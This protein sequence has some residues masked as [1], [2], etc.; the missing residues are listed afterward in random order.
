VDGLVSRYNVP[1]SVDNEFSA[2]DD[3]APLSPEWRREIER[4]KAACERGDLETIEAFEHLRSSRRKYD[5]SATPDPS[6][7]DRRVAAIEA[8]EIDGVTPEEFFRR[9]REKYGK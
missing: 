6:E 3:A 5:S 7:I 8:G 2:A 1:M 4:R 9:M